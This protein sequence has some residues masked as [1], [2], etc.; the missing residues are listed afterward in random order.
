MGAIPLADAIARAR[1]ALTAGQVAE[2]KG[3]VEAVRAAAPEAVAT[4]RLWGRLL[5]EEDV[6]AAEGVLARAVAVDPEDSEAWA[7][8]AEA[9]QRGGDGEAA[10]ALLQ[11]AWECAPWDRALVAQLAEW[12]GEHDDGGQLFPSRA[13]LASWYVAQGWWTRAAEECRAVLEEAPARWDLRQRYCVALWWLGVREEAAAE[14]ERVFAERPDMLGAVIVAAL[15]ARERG[16]EA[17]ARRYRELLWALDP[18]GEAIERL[19]PRERWEERSWLRMAEPVLVEE[20]WAAVSGGTELL[21][22]LPTDEEL[23]AARPAVGSEEAGLEFAELLEVEEALS[24]AVGEV[25]EVEGVAGEVEPV[26]TLPSEE[27]VEAA[28]P[29]EELER[30]WTTVLAELQASGLEPLAWEGIE[31]TVE[32]ASTERAVSVGEGEAGEKGV[33]LPGPETAEA[34]LLGAGV[35]VEAVGFG[36]AAQEEEREEATA[37][38]TVG[39]SVSRVEAVAEGAIPGQGAPREAT[40]S[41]VEEF[42]RLVGAGAEEEAVRLAQRIIQRGG[43][44]ELVPYLEELVHRGKRGARQAAMTL[45]AYYRRR[46]ETGQAARYYELALRLRSE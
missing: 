46:G 45:G 35:G 1:E 9:R 33:A 37:E 22:E 5:L 15:A 3:I 31:E 43:G 27:E 41:V 20:R 2:A 16:D 8:L 23:A 40:S 29:S 25:E 28:R 11:V 14:A 21:W 6:V 30:G 32:G 13:A 26:W 44:E 18:L 38:A 42:G 39:E 36:R 24:R 7:L 4:Y 17:S 19:V 34:P 10:R 12:S